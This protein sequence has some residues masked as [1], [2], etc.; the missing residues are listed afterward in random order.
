MPTRELAFRGRATGTSD[1]DIS[2]S[3][4]DS[5]REDVDQL[6]MQLVNTSPQPSS[7]LQFKIKYPIP[8]RDYFPKLIYF[9]TEACCVPSLY[10]AQN[11]LTSHLLTFYMNRA[12]ENPCLFVAVLFSALAHRDIA[13]GTP[14][15]PQTVYYQSLAI[16]MLREQLKDSNQMS[17]EMAATALSLTFYNMSGNN[18]DI[19]LIH[20]SGLLQIL[21][22]NQN[23]GP[24]FEALTAMVN[25]ILMGLSV[26]V[27]QEPPF[28]P[29]VGT[30]AN[31][32]A[33]V[34]GSDCM[35]S[36]VLRRAVIRVAENPNCLLTNDTISDL[37]N[38]LDF[39][40]AAENA[41][42]VELYTL[43]T[44][45]TPPTSRES[46]PEIEPTLLTK[47]AEII[48]QCCNLATTIF[49]SVLQNALRPDCASPPVD[50][51]IPH[52]AIK[53]LRAIIG[54]LDIVTWKKHAP[55]A[56]AWICFTAAAACDKPAGRVPFVTVVTPLLSASDSTELRL[57]RECW[58]YYKWL[59]GFSCLEVEED[60]CGGG[61]VSEISGSA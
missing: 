2:P 18:P 31:G 20:R 23:K 12:L 51:T 39:I 58:R 57:T 22:K 25:V 47:T 59:R 3:P 50:P 35:P 36:N 60:V 10:R 55:E 14:H 7:R 49:W 42:T 16:K 45:V 26:V 21:A 29:P 5:V 40:I 19:A 41:T 1:S 9:Y 37:H 46:S 13:Q 6:M 54:K 15:S 27:D 28:I 52:T 48:N 30:L 43:Y 44:A 34:F 33:F 17:Y 56:Y 32:G 11:S 38:V 4:P 8:E 53:I 61:V 24:E